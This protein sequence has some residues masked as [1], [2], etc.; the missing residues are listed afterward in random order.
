MRQ[1][2]DAVRRASDTDDLMRR[3]EATLAALPPAL[4]PGLGTGA[5]SAC[6]PTRERCGPRE[7]GCWQVVLITG[8]ASGI[9]AALARRM[10]APGRGLVLHTR[11]NTSAL[12]AVARDA[13]DRGSLVE[14]AVCDLSEAGAARSLVRAAEERFGA[15]DA[16]VANAGYADATSYEELSSS[17]LHRAFDTM[18]ASFLELTQAALPCLRRSTQARVVAVSSFIAHRYGE[19][20]RD[21]GGLFVASAASKAALES[22]AK[23]LARLLA[24]ECIPVNIVAPG[25]IEKDK[26]VGTQN[27]DERRK[28]VSSLVPMRRIGTP[29]DVVGPIVF[30]LSES[31]A[32]ITG[33]TIHVCGGLSTL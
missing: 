3:V 6:P 17:G 27:G 20:Y 10:A 22:A 2:S 8:A 15:L 32:Y 13:R 16:V 23:S 26:A 30:L 11:A 29:N 1:R 19:P 7:R 5:R 28:S 4:A 33:E 12:Q 9:G 21:G 25:H 24:P 31:A 18:A 14:L